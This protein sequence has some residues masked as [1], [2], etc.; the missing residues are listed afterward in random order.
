MGYGMASNLRKQI[1]L[2]STLFVYDVYR[3]LCDKF[4]IE[5][6]GYGPIEI[7][8]SIKETV[9][10][11]QVL[12]SSLPSL[13][14]ICEV[15]L[16]EATGVLAANPNPGRLVLDTSTM[17]QSSAAELAQQLAEAKAGFYVD[18]PVSVR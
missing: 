6:G 3:P 9:E 5:F 4:K 18:A 16:D 8:G 1:P 13:E 7:K 17:K 14:A 11:A 2:S 15:Y 10:Y 12:V